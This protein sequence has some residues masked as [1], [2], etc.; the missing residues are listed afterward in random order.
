MFYK[1]WLTL[2]NLSRVL[3]GARGSRGYLQLAIP[4]ASSACGTLTQIRRTAML[5]RLEN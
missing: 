5:L 3:F 2:P 4:E 1:R